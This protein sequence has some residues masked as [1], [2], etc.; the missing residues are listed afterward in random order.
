MSLGSL[1]AVRGGRRVIGQFAAGIAVV[2]CLGGCGSGIAGHLTMV[3]AAAVVPTPPRRLTAHRLRSR[4]GAVAL[5]MMVRSSSIFTDRVFANAH[6]GVALASDGSAQYPVVTTD[7]AHWRIAGPQVHVDAA[8][9]AEGVGYVG[10]ASSRTFFAYGSS[11]VDVTTD[12][13]RGWWETYLGELVTAVV[14]GPGGGLVAYVQRQLNSSG[15]APVVTWQY[16]S[17]DGG[18]HWIYSTALGGG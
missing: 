14:P 12:R 16:I 2:V 6:T 15:S 1:Q 7:G 8:D 13:G 4:P 11:V 3:R 18:R 10:V 5:G 9:G 17:R